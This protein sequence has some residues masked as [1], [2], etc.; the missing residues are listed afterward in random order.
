MNVVLPV[1][2]GYQVVAVDITGD[3]GNITI[4]DAGSG[5]YTASSSVTVPAPSGTKVTGGGFNITGAQI[6]DYP[7]AD[8]PA[9]DGT[10][11]TFV[12]DNL[13]ANISGDTGSYVWGVV[14]AI[15][16]AV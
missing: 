2:T 1:T 15:C 8:G 16:M 13:S 11:W 5:T 3:N 7:S 14:Y 12:C 9:S 10:S 6:Q 4:T